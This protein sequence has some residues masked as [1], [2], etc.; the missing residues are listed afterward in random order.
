[1]KITKIF[2]QHFRSLEQRE[3]DFEQLTLLVGGNGTGKTS[4]I[5]GLYLLSHGESFRAGKVDEMIEFDQE[6][7]RVGVRLE[8]GQAG[9]ADKLEVTLTKGKVQGKRTRKRLFTINDAGKS[10]KNFVGQFSSVVFQPEDMRLVE[11]S[12]YRRRSFMDDV[13]KSVDRQYAQ[14]LH[15]YE[16]ALKR[17]NK[18]LEQVRE[19][20]Q[21]ES[22]LKYWEMTLVKHGEILQ[23]KRNDFFD[24]LREM[25]SPFNFNVRYKISKISEE[26]LAKRRSRAIAAGHMLVGPHKDD[27]EALFAGEGL[28]DRELSVYG[29]RG[30]QR[31]GVLWLKLGELKFLEHQQEQKPLLLLDD[32]FSELDE[33]SQQLVLELI[34]DYQTVI[35]TAD[36]D[37]KEFLASELTKLKVIKMTNSLKH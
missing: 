12:P 27:F 5:E 30:Q 37:T 11:G 9:Q 36:Q 23:K 16:Q 22:V 17:L 19:G 31:L 2:F 26:D 1:M 6:L 4:V 21:P 25:E 29:S 8:D 15:T 18:F 13:L 10:L 7:A 14:S 3:I 20:E 33:N 32:I 34:N 24:F 28:E 35:T